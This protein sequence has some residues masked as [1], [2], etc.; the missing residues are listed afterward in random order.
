M[1]SGRF[2]SSRGFVVEEPV[3][4]H[5]HQTIQAQWETNKHNMYISLSLY[6]YMSINSDHPHSGR[7]VSLAPLP[8]TPHSPPQALCVDGTVQSVLSCALLQGRNGTTMMTRSQPY[9]GSLRPWS[10]NGLERPDLLRF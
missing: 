2:L 6:I 7:H 9:A 5:Y 10:N 3:F 8:Q 1:L 4:G